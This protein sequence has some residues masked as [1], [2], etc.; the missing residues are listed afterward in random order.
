MKYAHLHNLQKLVSLLIHIRKLI[1]LLVTDTELKL[2]PPP[3][4]ERLWP[5]P[6]VT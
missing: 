5:G 6:G 2:V 3:V 1:R 4:A